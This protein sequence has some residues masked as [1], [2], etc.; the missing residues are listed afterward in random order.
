MASK[1]IK[2][3]KRETRGILNLEILISSLFKDVMRRDIKGARKRAR[4]L[5]RYERKL[6]MRHNKLF[7]DIDE[8]E[9]NA[10]PQC[11]EKLEI[12]KQKTN[13]FA[14]DMIKKFSR[15]VGEIPTELRKPIPNWDLLKADLE[16]AVGEEN[17]WL[18]LERELKKLVEWAEGGAINEHIWSKEVSELKNLGL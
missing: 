7:E 2:D 4:L 16:R 14:A 3:S 6:N 18:V 12:F 15:R 11:N 5:S 13:V 17:G 10:P 8:L 1:I 9:K